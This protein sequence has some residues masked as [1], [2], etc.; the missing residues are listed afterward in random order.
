MSLKQYTCEFSMPENIH[1]NHEIIL[2]LM[3]VEPRPHRAVLY[4]VDRGTH[5]SAARFVQ[6]EPAEDV[7]NTLESCWTSIYIV[8]TNILPHDYGECYAA[9]FCCAATENCSKVEN[10]GNETFGSSPGSEVR[11]YGEK[12]NSWGGPFKLISYDGYNTAV[13][14]FK[15]RPVPFPTS[16]ITIFLR[17]FNNVVDK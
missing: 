2:H 7:W 4:I 5:F 10:E 9:E 6:G 12:K 17:E 1:F 11:V 14:D 15:K 13:V 3:W 16:A 8:F